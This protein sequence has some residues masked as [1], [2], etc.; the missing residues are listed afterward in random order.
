M[1]P[2]AGVR[3][4]G[5][6]IRLLSATE[7]AQKSGLFGRKGGG[8]ASQKGHEHAIHC[9][10]CSQPVKQDQVSI[11]APPTY[12]TMSASLGCMTSAAISGMLCKRP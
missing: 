7:M 5:E 10:R 12:M 11:L 9:V 4:E 3:Q 8:E 2:T 1:E 6:Q